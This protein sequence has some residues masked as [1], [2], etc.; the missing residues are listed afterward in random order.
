MLSAEEN[1]VTLVTARTDAEQ[2]RK[3]ASSKTLGAQINYTTQ[4]LSDF[5]DA[6]QRRKMTCDSFAKALCSDPRGAVGGLPLTRR[7]AAAGVRVGDEAIVSYAVVG[8]AGEGGRVRSRCTVIAAEGRNGMVTVK[9]LRED[10]RHASA[11]HAEAPSR[12]STLNV[13]VTELFDVT[14]L[15]EENAR[16]FDFGF[17]AESASGRRKRAGSTTA[18]CVASIAPRFAFDDDV[19]DAAQRFAHNG[20]FGYLG[21]KGGTRTF[22]NPALP[23]PFRARHGAGGV[24]LEHRVGPAR[25]DATFQPPPAVGK[26]SDVCGDGKAHVYTF[27]GSSEGSDSKHPHAHHHAQKRAPA[28]TATIGR[29]GFGSGSARRSFWPFIVT[30]QHGSSL[31]VGGLRSFVIEGRRAT[32]AM[33]PI[34]YRGQRSRAAGGGGSASASNGSEWVVLHVE[35]KQ[36][37]SRWLRRAAHESKAKLTANY[38]ARTFRIDSKVQCWVTALRVRMTS[39]NESGM[40]SLS[41]SR[42]EAWGV[43]YEPNGFICDLDQEEG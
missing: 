9:L 30:T 31:P 3:T 22:A 38:A 39:K 15:G 8:A 32:G 24:N 13:H 2:R 17:V 10:E 23:T 11:I 1:T 43:V 35:T 20:I 41:L 37:P 5:R 25:V 42:L 29:S 28:W 18:W 16:R 4:P 14:T 40:W 12:P 21:S 26:A 34:G 33:R 6:A 36:K 19:F 27:E 7:F